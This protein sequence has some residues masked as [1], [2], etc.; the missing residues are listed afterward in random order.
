[1]TDPVGELLHRRLKGQILL[2]LTE[3]TPLGC[4]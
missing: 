3:A 4:Q 2:R 1:M